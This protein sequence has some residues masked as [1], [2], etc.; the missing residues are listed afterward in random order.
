MGYK[1]SFYDASKIGTLFL[2]RIAD[3]EKEADALSV[4]ASVNDK[5]KIALMIIDMQI[6]FCHKNGTLYV[7]G[8]EGDIER[9]ITFILNNLDKLTT[10]FASLDS[11]LLFQIFYRSWWRAKNNLKP[12]VYSEIAKAAMDAGDFHAIIDPVKSIDYETALEAN[13]KKKLM[14]WPYH[15][16]LG[17][18]G[19]ALDPSLY[20]ILAFHSFAR[21]SQLNFLQKGLIPQSEMYGILKPE[22]PVPGHKQGGFNVDFLNLL[23]KHDKLI[24]TGQA[25]SHCVLES[26]IQ[27][28]DYFSKSNP[29]VLK[30][31]YI[32]EDC[33]SSVKHP[34]VDFEAIAQAE[35]TK[36]KKAGMNIIKSVDFKV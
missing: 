18:P 31:V 14:I 10:I 30:K 34:L 33:M 13:S 22:V 4:S 28:H 19:Q 32:F 20:E 35:F 27:I 9:L 3:V 23:M 29:D 1:P 26:I 11:H 25:K 24:I 36:F 17:T 21:K 2:P 5:T 12:D 8:A 6:D 16:E 7:D 15:T